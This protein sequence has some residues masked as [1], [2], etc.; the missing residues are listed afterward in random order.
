M[1]E[2]SVIAAVYFL[3]G[4]GLK[5]LATALMIRPQGSEAGSRKK[6]PARPAEF[7]VGRGC[8]GSE[9]DISTQ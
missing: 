8:Y 5:R 2:T 9:F 7:G 4:G 1:G 6:G 3:T